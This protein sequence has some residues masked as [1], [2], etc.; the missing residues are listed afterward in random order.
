MGSISKDQKSD[1]SSHCP[2]P[3]SDPYGDLKL[4][5]VVRHLG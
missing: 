5:A 3:F 2:R 4:G 1:A